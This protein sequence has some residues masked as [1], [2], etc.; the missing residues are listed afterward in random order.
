MFMSN[1]VSCQ[2]LYQTRCLVSVYVK[3]GVLSVFVS[4]LPVDKGSFQC[5]LCQSYLLMRCLVSVC[6]VSGQCSAM[7]YI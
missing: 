3:Q 7:W 2:F 4:V 6:Y 1:K 5:V